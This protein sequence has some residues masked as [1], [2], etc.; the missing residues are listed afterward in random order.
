MPAVSNTWCTRRG[1]GTMRSG[2]PRPWRSLAT[3]STSPM[4]VESMKETSDRSSVNDSSAGASIA[5]SRAGSAT[6][7]APMS[8]SPASAA[9]TAPRSSTTMGEE[10]GVAMRGRSSLRTLPGNMDLTFTER[11]TTFRDE[12]R[13]WFAAN[14]PGD[15]PTQDEDAHYA[16]RRDFQ[17]RLAQDGLAAV[18]WPPEYG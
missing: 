15:E 16:W 2:T 4:P 8:S 14:P 13:A 6:N 10:G 18:H 7:V 5:R 9:V 3:R 1:P 11:E 12:L 17:R